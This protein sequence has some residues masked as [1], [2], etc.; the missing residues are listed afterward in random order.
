M[1]RVWMIFLK[2]KNINSKNVFLPMWIEKWAHEPIPIFLTFAFCAFFAIFRDRFLAYL[3]SMA[4]EAV[5]KSDKKWALLHKSFF[6]THSLS[7]ITTEIREARNAL[8]LP[9]SLRALCSLW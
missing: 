4:C 2:E 1:A 8:F 6:A 3:K 5:S 9:F 7:V